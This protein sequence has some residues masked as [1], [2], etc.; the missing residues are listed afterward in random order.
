MLVD[1]DVGGGGVKNAGKSADVINGRPHFSYSQ[2]I[3]VTRYCHDRALE[4]GSNAEHKSFKNKRNAQ[5]MAI[6]T[7]KSKI[8]I[9]AKLILLKSCLLGLV[10]L[11]ICRNLRDVPS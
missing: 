2:E 11:I 1:A 8:F 9:K 4:S 5:K 6:L 10:C 7:K 3:R